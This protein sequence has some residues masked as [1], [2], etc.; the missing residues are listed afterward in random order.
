MT[1]TKAD[2]PG[3]A[4]RTTAG[5]V[6]IDYAP[7][8]PRFR[9]V[10]GADVDFPPIDNG[11]DYLVSV[12]D[13][14][15]RDEDDER[16]GPRNLKY[17]VLHLQAAAEV[18]LK[19]RLEIEHWTLVAEQITNRKVTREKFQKGDFISIGPEEAVRRIRDI[20]GETI[21]K[22]EADSL[23]TLTARRNALQHYKM[24]TTYED[25]E[26]LTTK[27]LAFLLRFLHQ[28]LLPKLSPEERERV[29]G[30]I[31]LV[32]AGANRLQRYVSE[33]MELL[34]P[35]LAGKDDC[36]VQ[37]TEC[38]QD[39]LLVTGDSGDSAAQAATCLFCHA[40]WTAAAVATDYVLRFLGGLFQ[41]DIAPC[42]GCGRTRT[43][44]RH[45]VRST[46]WKRN[47][48]PTSHPV[49]DS[50]IF[51]FGCAAPTTADM[52]APRSAS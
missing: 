22:D 4:D 25:I 7:P 47:P 44:V 34:T 27:V 45:V 17:A 52:P 3:R 2:D 30:D 46:E 33:R 29:Q 8:L 32:Q 28:S 43:V 39:A 36:T 50:V 51:C 16:P 20:L 24:T 35:E 48:D 6:G 19:A 21:T 31:A 49:F 15:S 5:V 26:A 11:L 13:G 9:G 42:P 12:V 14:L 37:C 18:L 10:A 38:R 41:H 40:T 23:T 1:D